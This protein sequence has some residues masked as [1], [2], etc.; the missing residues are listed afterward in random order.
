MTH[1]GA[2]GADGVTTLAEFES[3][4]RDALDPE[5]WDY[6]STGAADEVTLRWNVARW[7]AYRLLPRVLADATR[8]DT[9]VRVL[10]LDLPHPVIVAPTATHARYH[11]G[12]ERATLAGAAA[13]GSAM[14][15]STLSSIDVAEFGDAARGTGA[16][17]F[18]QAYVQADRG[19]TRELLQRATAS[20]ARAILLTVDTPTLGARARDRREPS[21]AA[22]GQSYP[23][24]D[25]A[26]LPDPEPDVPRRLRIFNPHLAPD[27]TW[28]DV[29]WVVDIVDV[30][31]LLKGVMR[32]DDAV[33]A[34]DHGAAGVVVSNH[35]ARNLDTVPATVDVLAGIVDASR[36]RAVLV[37]GGIRRGTDIA[38]AL[39]LGAD[40]VLVGRPIAWGLAAHGADGVRRVVEILV[41]E[42][43]MAM[44]LLGTPTR[45][46]LGRDALW[47]P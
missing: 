47:A 44:A 21:G 32:P 4:A 10:G 28:S 16:T 11:P 24:L 12:G 1:P 17:W 2:A 42:L 46:E 9:G 22:P 25:A 18:F 13:A 15:L 45:A 31:V 8:L 6:L 26:G 36:G 30:P 38:K 41:T 5:T 27:L 19:Y 3:I 33:R 23:N 34:G 40:A 35:G 29:E 39:A 43:R 14:T 7:E 37:D 20:G